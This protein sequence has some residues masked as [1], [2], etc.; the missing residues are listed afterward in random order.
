MSWRF[1]IS[2]VLVCSATL[3]AAF[4]LIPRVESPATNNRPPDKQSALDI[5]QGTCQGCHG[6]TGTRL[7]S[8][9]AAAAIAPAPSQF[10][11][12]FADGKLTLNWQTFPFFSPDLIRPISRTDAPDGDGWT[13]LVTDETYGGFAS[14]SYAGAE[15]LSDYSIEAWIYTEVNSGQVAPIHGLAVRVDPNALRFYRLGVQFGAEPKISFAY[16]GRDINDFPDYLRSWSAAEIPGGMPASGGWHRLGLR[17][18]GDHFWAYWDNQELPGGPVV[19]GRISNGYFGIY[20]NFVGTEQ[21]A[22]TF[23]DGIT[24]H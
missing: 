13:G 7:E 6:N 24:V 16:V 19:D 22:Q 17:A 2:I 4:V 10:Q 20:D 18:E 3:A 8:I 14:M 11:E 21:V 23:V 9:P 1:A 12:D 15:T 5:S